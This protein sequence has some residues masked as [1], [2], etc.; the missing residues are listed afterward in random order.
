MENFT[1]RT[2]IACAYG[3]DVAVF[4]HNI[5]YWVEQN[6]ANGSNFM[7][8]RYWTYNSMDAFAKLY[9][10]WS[11]DQVKRIINKCRENDLLLVGEY[12]ENPYLRTKWYSPSDKLLAL[13]GIEMTVDGIWRNRHM[14][15]DETAQ[16]TCGEIANS[17]K[18]QDNTQENNPLPPKSPK[19][20]IRE[21]FDTYAGG[22]TQLRQLL[23]DFA[24]SRAKTNKSPLRTERQAKILLG[25]LDRLS[26]G[27]RLRKIALLEKAIM[28]GWKSLYPLKADELP[29][30]TTGPG[31]PLRGEGVRYL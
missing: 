11:K 23:D 18:E 30:A 10:M 19:R 12:N 27:D 1:G 29:Q 25:K 5:V 4:V 9:P 20:Q 28:S 31:Q 13:Y 16:C 6:A 22:D 2:D 3:L 17:I 8:G 21:I 15:E 26:D 24:E 7:D 14:E